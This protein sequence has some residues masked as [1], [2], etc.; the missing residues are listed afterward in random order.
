MA[1]ATL[2]IEARTIFLDVYTAVVKEVRLW[3]PSLNLFAGTSGKK[4]WL[5]IRYLS[6]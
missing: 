4:A 2:M 3:P 1:A 6:N 5:V